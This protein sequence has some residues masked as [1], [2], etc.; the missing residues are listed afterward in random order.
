MLASMAATMKREREWDAEAGGNKLVKE[1]PLPT[2]NPHTRL[3]Y[4]QKFYDIFAKRK[5]ASLPVPV[6]L[7][8][9]HLNQC[10]HIQQISFYLWLVPTFRAAD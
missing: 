10:E 7:C 8:S 1:E 5:G 9:K 2:I 4:S 6:Y 3:P